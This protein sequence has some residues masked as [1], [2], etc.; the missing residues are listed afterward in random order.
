MVGQS[1]ALVSRVLMLEW[2]FIV[3]CVSVCAMLIKFFS[4][5]RR[6]LA[7]EKR[8]DDELAEISRLTPEQAETK[9]LTELPRIATGRPWDSDIP[10]S[11]L[12]IFPEL[13]ESIRDLFTKYKT[14]H[15]LRQ[16]C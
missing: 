13:H 7:A 15:W 14:I 2:L 9:V 5:V 11:A 16:E 4:G 8:V 6:V 3:L 12:L 10:H 1:V